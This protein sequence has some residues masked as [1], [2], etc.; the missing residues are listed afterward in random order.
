M[1]KRHKR[2]LTL[3]ALVLLLA[4]V[5]LMTFCNITAIAVTKEESSGS[6]FDNE[7]GNASVSYEETS[8]ERLKWTVHLTKATQETATRFMVEVTGDGQAVTP[9]N[10]Q[11]L[12]KSNPTM[13]FAAGN[14]AGQ[15]TAGMSETAATTTGSAV[16]T[17]DTNRSYTAM[18]VKPKLIAD[19]TPATD[20]LAGNTG[21]SFTIPQ[22]ATSESTSENSAVA[23]SEAPVSESSATEA[24]SS[25]EV[26]ATEETTAT[27]EVTESTSTEQSA[28]TD[29]TTASTEATEESDVEDEADAESDVKANADTGIVPA[30]S[31]YTGLRFEKTW[32]FPDGVP[33]PLPDEAQTVQVQIKRRIVG[34]TT[35]DKYQEPKD[36]NY[37]D[38]TII[39]G[40]TVTVDEWHNLPLY[41]ADGKQYEYTLEELPN[42]YYDSEQGKTVDSTISNVTEVPNNNESKWSYTDTGFIIASIKG[43]WFIWTVDPVLDKEAF[44]NNVK[45]Y[46]GKP[47]GS[48]NSFDKF[49]TDATLSNTVWVTGNTDGIID[50]VDY[51]ITTEVEYK[52]TGEFVASIIFGATKLWTQFF[53]GGHTT[54]MVPITN[55]YNPPTKITV[56]KNWNDESNAYNTR[57]DIQLVV[58][59][60]L[61]GETGW[62]V[63]DDEA[64]PFNIDNDKEGNT[65]SHDFT[66]P[67][68]VDGK[69]AIY[70]VVEMV[71]N[72]STGKYEERAV[73]GYDDPYYSD[74]NGLAA[75]TLSVDNNLITY[76]ISVQKIWNDNENAYNTRK[77]IQLVLQRQLEGETLW[78][79]VGTHDIAS[80]ATE[81]A[82]LSKMFEN[83]PSVVDGLNATYRVIERVTVDGEVQE[84]VPG[85]KAP[86]YDPASIAESG[87]LTVTNELLTT[88]LG[89]T[90][91][92]N[93]E[94]TPLSGVSFT[95]TGE[96][97]G[98]K[99]TLTTGDDGKVLFEDLLELNPDLIPELDS[100]NPEK[101]GYYTLTETGLPGYLSAG[102]WKFSVV[103]NETSNSMEIVWKDGKSPLK[104]DKLVNTLKPFDLTVNKTDDQGKALKGAEFTLV[105]ANN[106]KFTATVS[107][108]G[109]TFTFT[110]LT[111][112]GEYTLTEV[113]A[114]E[115]YRKLETPIKIVIDELGNVTIDEGEEQAKET[116]TVSENGNYQI[117]LTVANDPKA[118]L[119]STGGPGTLLFTLIGMVT[120][121]A[122]GMYVFFRKDQE[123]A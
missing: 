91:V 45:G 77:D 97:N 75:G 16:I 119:P 7:F 65:F 111:P 4:Q 46:T 42:A 28:T 88:K 123:V 31:H 25:T 83:V 10:V 29:S 11:V 9:E 87:N 21:K 60:Q 104:D 53:Y 90:K 122:A 32:V 93:D 86:A 3:A 95:V 81:D 62:T 59:R 63:V 44:M 33:S 112:P 12:T 35:W 52:D 14:G 73:K 18:T 30:E 67:S 36:I 68:K 5:F 39:D 15:I 100:D 103:Y 47:G 61:A 51:G 79:D 74:P 108:D 89:F 76:D 109:A 64:N 121:G 105:D 1:V 70:K 40:K 114:P 117:T 49:K 113:K 106:N 27:S 56:Q 57:E 26:A 94:S 22:V 48:G 84:R 120:L 92:D 101:D 41:D 80:G 85:Y 107:E 34:S 82:D 19:V 58:K 98:Y 8:T 37:S 72:E 99:K 118:P 23:A 78:S 71:L 96:E 6:L 69:K 2:S 55:T 24:T 20:L 17:F 54:A 102:P 110:G 38:A 115:G 66:L 43:K 116:L 13:N 50:G